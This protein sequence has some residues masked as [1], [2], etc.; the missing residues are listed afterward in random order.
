MKNATKEGKRGMGKCSCLSL[1]CDFGRYCDS[2][3][4]VHNLSQLTNSFPQNCSAFKILHLNAHELTGSRENTVRLECCIGSGK[5][6][7][8]DNCEPMR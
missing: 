3:R 7:R 4:F 1:L 6:E 8:H 5:R 2:S